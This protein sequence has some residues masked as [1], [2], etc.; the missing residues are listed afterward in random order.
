MEFGHVEGHLL[1]RSIQKPEL[2]LLYVGSIENPRDLQFT[3]GLEIMRGGKVIIC[4]PRRRLLEPNA[5]EEREAA[6]FI[7][8]TALKSDHFHGILTAMRNGSHQAIAVL[9]HPLSGRGSSYDI[10]SSVRWHAVISTNIGG[11]PDT[12]QD[13]ANGIIMKENNPGSICAALI[14]F[15]DNRNLLS[16]ISG[17]KK[18]LFK[19]RFDLPYS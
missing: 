5:G 19:E 14:Y 13:G 17:N 6:D 1:I 9:L 2:N 11:I 3:S 15:C 16:L 18:T 8:I 4:I 12:I 7:A 10:G